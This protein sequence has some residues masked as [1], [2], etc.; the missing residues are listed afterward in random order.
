MMICGSE[1]SGMA[2]SATVRS[3]YALTATSAATRHPTIHRKRMTSSMIAVIMGDRRQQ[4]VDRRPLRSFQ[5]VVRVDEEAAE[6]HDLFVRL[7]TTV[8]FGEQLALQARLDF[9]LHVASRVLHVDDASA[10][11]LDDGLVRDRQALDLL[12]HDL[13]H[14]T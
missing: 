2:S 3:A 5:L 14:V 8:D 9:P 4:S 7:E 13:E 1:M 11:G 10:A 6:G 12:G